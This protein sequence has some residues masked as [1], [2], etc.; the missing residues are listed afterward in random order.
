MRPMFPGLTK[1]DVAKLSEEQRE[2]IARIVLDQAQTKRKL[3]EKADG[4][5]GYHFIPILFLIVAFGSGAFRSEKYVPFIIIG[6]TG[7]SSSTL[8][9]STRGSTPL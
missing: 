5:F 8:L 3:Q 1:D 2:A 7:S 6:L 9:A 4:Y